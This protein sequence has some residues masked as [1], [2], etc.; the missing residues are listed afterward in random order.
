MKCSAQ[1][2]AAP[3]AGAAHCPAPS[4]ICM[5][6]AYARVALADK[7]K[8]TTYNSGGTTVSL[9]ELAALVVA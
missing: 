8:H 1:S 3:A 7:P 4:M 9:G 2:L 6:E 5:A